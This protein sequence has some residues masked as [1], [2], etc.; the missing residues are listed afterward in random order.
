ML[1]LSLFS[2]AANAREHVTIDHRDTGGG[3]A[4]LPIETPVEPAPFQSEQI[5]G[6]LADAGEHWRIE[7]PH[8]PVHVWTPEAYD[9]KT[10]STIVFVH[11]YH[12]DVDAAWSDYRLEQQFALSGLNA[13]FIAPA[14]PAN[15]RQR[16]AWPSLDALL[17]TVAENVDAPMPTKRLIAVGHSGAY[18]TLASW[19]SNARLD[20][21]IL[22]DA[23]YAEYSFAPWV[24]ASQSRRLVNIA[25]ET[26][27]YSDYMH[28]RLPET[29]HVIGL[30][31]DGQPLPEA[32]IL[33]VK[34]FAGHYPL[35]NDGYALPLALRAVDAPYVQNAPLDLPLGL[36]ERCL[37]DP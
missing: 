8:G 35:A 17:K 24:R 37:L 7:T 2:A 25:Y 31:H 11:G 20:S 14:A 6:A 27:R 18:R 33:Y 36:S 10:A 16:I 29:R 13:M 5:L 9:P 34:T 1:A 4:L 28:R 32:R 12:T 3:P 21:M 23:V 19:L 26:D 30:P 22:L 15:K